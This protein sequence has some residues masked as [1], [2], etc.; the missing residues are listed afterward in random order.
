M[1]TKVSGWP[2]IA[3]K[4]IESELPAIAAGDAGKVLTVVEDN[5]GET[6]VYKTEWA[7][8]KA[9]G[10]Q[11]TVGSILSTALTVSVGSLVQQSIQASATKYQYVSLSAPLNDYLPDAMSIRQAVKKCVNDG[12]SATIS[13]LGQSVVLQTCVMGESNS[14][15]EYTVCGTIPAYGV[16]VPTVGYYQFRIVVT[17]SFVIDDSDNISAGSYALTV[18]PVVTP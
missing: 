18:E 16:T 12:V 6:P 14:T 5:S 17:L 1:S 13:V 7:E 15:P 2:L 4:E 10:N 11:C 8:P 3:P 9:V